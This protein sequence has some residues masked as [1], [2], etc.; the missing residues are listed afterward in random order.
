MGQAKFDAQNKAVSIPQWLFF[1]KKIPL[2]EIKGKTEKMDSSSGSKVFNLTLTGDFG[3]QEISFGSYEE[4]A[5]FIYEY[6]KANL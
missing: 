2:S 5:T 3:E 6:Q 4:Y 1:S